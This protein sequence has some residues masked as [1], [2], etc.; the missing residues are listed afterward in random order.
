MQ[1]E[2]SDTIAPDFITA[3]IHGNP[4]RILDGALRAGVIPVTLCIPSSCILML[5]LSRTASL[6]SRRTVL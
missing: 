1:G 4:D 6:G 3:I 5:R 2:S